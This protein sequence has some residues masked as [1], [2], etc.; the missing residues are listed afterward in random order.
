[1]TP[2]TRDVGRRVAAGRSLMRA[3][4]DP[5]LEGWAASIC[6]TALDLACGEGSHIRA[7]SSRAR[8]VGLDVG[9]RPDVV[10]DLN[11]PLPIHSDS[12]DAAVLSWFLY[13]A[14]DPAALLVEVHRVLRPGGVLLLTAPLVFP[15]TPEPHDLWR[16]TG[17]GLERLAL[18]AG[19]TSVT[20]V[21]FG[22][23]W[24]SAM[25]LLSPFLRPRRVIHSP[26]ARLCV[27]LDA[28]TARRFGSRLPPNPLGY[29]MRA[30]A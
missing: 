6:G 22:G 7:S 10:A 15:V 18:E 9:H 16:F 5:V 21:P 19:Y 30:V 20:I 28:L 29:C 24:T 2:D 17:E 4:S 27:R 8:W 3:L 13:I 1:M 12:A 14:P 26:L 11:A 23:R 25:Y